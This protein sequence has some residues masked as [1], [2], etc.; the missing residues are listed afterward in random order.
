MCLQV[1]LR[2]SPT[3]FVAADKDVV[4]GG[5]LGVC[6]IF[7]GGVMSL[8][9]QGPLDL[10]WIQCASYGKLGSQRKLIVKSVSQSNHKA[11]DLLCSVLPAA[12]CAEHLG[13]LI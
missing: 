9:L 12:R 1:T 7:F 8:R 11:H 13:Q 10:A 2:L 4:E 3:R 5:C 6:F